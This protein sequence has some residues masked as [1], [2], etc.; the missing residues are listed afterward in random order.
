MSEIKFN[1]ALKQD[2]SIIQI[3][4]TDPIIFSNPFPHSL[5]VKI[6]RE[7]QYGDI[8]LNNYDFEWFTHHQDLSNMGKIALNQG[9]YR[10]YK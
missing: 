2:G 6:L 1:Q 8:R 9:I 5:Q 10:F 7:H 3:K 4:V